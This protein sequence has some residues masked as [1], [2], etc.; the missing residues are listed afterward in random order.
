M[1]AEPD[2]GPAVR[3]VGLVD[4]ALEGVEGAFGVLGGRFRLV[5]QFTKIEK[6]LL[7]GAALGQIRAFPFVDEFLGRHGAAAAK[8][9]MLQFYRWPTSN[10]MFRIAVA[11]GV[12]LRTLPIRQP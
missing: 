1:A 10:A 5:Q 12:G 6:V 9:G 3:A 4:A 2:I 11:L 7:V 8:F